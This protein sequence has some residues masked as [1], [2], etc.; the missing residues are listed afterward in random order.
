MNVVM[1][2][3]PEEL[4]EQVQRHLVILRTRAASDDWNEESVAVLYEQLDEPARAVLTAV[5]RAV[6]DDEAPTVTGIAE[7]TG[8]S[9]R[10]VRGIV[11]EITHRFRALR[12]P[13]FPLM[14]LDPMD[15]L[16][17]DKGLDDDNR[18]IMISEDGARFVLSVAAG[19]S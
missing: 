3:V 9:A 6:A 2:P 7:A 13:A 5:A 11:V 4:E 18:P 8:T 17:P 14:L 10:E 19:G 15:G 1:V 12:G 16:D